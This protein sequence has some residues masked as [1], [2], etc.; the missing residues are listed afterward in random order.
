MNDPFSQFIGDAYTIVILFGEFRVIGE[1]YNVVFIS[2]VQLFSGVLEHVLTVI[3]IILVTCTAVVPFVLTCS[4]LV[5][6]SLPD[7]TPCMVWVRDY[8]CC[9]SLYGVW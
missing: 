1:F 2:V 7:H 5:V 3:Y 4:I 8:P 9:N 6:V